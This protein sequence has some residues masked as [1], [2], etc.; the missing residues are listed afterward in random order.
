MCSYSGLLLLVAQMLGNLN[1]IRLLSL[2][3]KGL[4]N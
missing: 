3:A 1:P 4:C 2:L